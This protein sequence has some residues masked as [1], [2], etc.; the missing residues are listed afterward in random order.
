MIDFGPIEDKSINIIKVIGVGGGEC[1]AVRNMCLFLLNY[2]NKEIDL[3]PIHKDVYML[4]LDHPAGTL[5][6]TLRA[7]TK[8]GLND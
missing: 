8:R 3:Q 4:F 1:N 7:Q 5:R 6:N 2:D